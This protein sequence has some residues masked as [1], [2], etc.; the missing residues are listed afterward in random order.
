MIPFS[1]NAVITIFVWLTMQASEV[2]FHVFVRIAGQLIHRGKQACARF[3]NLKSV[4]LLKRTLMYQ[5]PS[6]K[7]SPQK[8]FARVSLRVSLSTYFV[9][10]DSWYMKS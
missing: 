9:L 2:F 7:A 6:R 4:R 10:F 3:G 1:N 8:I 5:S